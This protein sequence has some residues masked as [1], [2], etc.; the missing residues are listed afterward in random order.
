[1]AVK[2]GQHVFFEADEYSSYGTVYQVHDREDALGHSYIAYTVIEDGTG[3]NYHVMPDT[4]DVI[5]VM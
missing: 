3:Q 1:M 2:K 4:G 5:E